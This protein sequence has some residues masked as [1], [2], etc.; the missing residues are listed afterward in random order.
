LHGHLRT[1]CALKQTA[2]AGAKRRFVAIKRCLLIK[3]QVKPSTL[4]PS[5][6][7]EPPPLRLLTLIH[8]KTSFRQQPLLKKQ[9]S[10]PASVCFSAGVRQPVSVCLCVSHLCLPAPGRAG[11]LLLPGPRDNLPQDW[12]S[13]RCQDIRPCAVRQVVCQQ[14]ADFPIGGT[15]V[16]LPT[17]GPDEKAPLTGFLIGTAPCVNIPSSIEQW[18]GVCH[19]SICRPSPPCSHHGIKRQ[20][21]PAKR[22][23][24]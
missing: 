11:G 18:V 16:P 7:A 20:P 6:R 17:G 9:P 19:L 21:N 3:T 24:V 13:C 5:V 4:G 8:M 12:V 14:S 15:A 2:A 10:L 23:V 1:A 22:T